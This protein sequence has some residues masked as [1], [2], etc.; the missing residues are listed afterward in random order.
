[1]RTCTVCKQTKAETEFY[2][3]N[4]RPSGFQSRCKVCQNELTYKWRADHPQEIA[5]HKHKSAQSHNHWTLQTRYGITEDEYQEMYQRQ[6]GL[7]AACN[8]PS[9]GKRRLHVDHDHETGAVRGL[10][11]QGCNTV[12]G[13]AHD[14]V[15][16][17]M[18]LA[19]YLLQSHDLLAKGY[20][21]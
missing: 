20:T 11:C 15:D 12:L 17:L 21:P 3:R 10:L 19:A 9:T 4:D 13:M 5:E 7:C 14:D 6:N 16:R 18:S 1:M 8:K 2:R